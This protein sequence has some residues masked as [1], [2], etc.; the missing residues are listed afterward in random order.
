MSRI[1]RYSLAVYV[2]LLIAGTVA[3]PPDQQAQ[4]ARPVTAEQVQPAQPP[5]SQR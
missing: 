5:A 3:P 2:G 4:A 1:I